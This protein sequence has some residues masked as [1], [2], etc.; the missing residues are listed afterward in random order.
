M[1][2]TLFADACVNFD[3]AHV[4]DEIKRQSICINGDIRQVLNRI[5][6]K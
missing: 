6:E 5:D 3:E 1:F 2:F 4:P